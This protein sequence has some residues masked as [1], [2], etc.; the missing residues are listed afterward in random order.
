MN[1]GQVVVGAVFGNDT[2][3]AGMKMMARAKS[4]CCARRRLGA[5]R[6][7]TETPAARR[8]RARRRAPSPRRRSPPGPARRRRNKRRAWSQAAS[9][10]QIDR[11]GRAE[12]RP[13]PA[14]EQ[15]GS[16]SISRLRSCAQID[17]S[18]ATIQVER[19][20]GRRGRAR[21]RRKFDIPG[22][23]AG[24]PAQVYRQT[25]QVTPNAEGVAVLG[26]TVSLKHDDCGADRQRAAFDSAIL[27]D[28]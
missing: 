25:V 9:S 16:R 7:P 19:R 15:W 22:D 5:V 24:L 12:I 27:A 18:A 14:A 26:V 21:C 1:A 3:M 10:G 4:C 20:R 17:A 28:R 13:C 2:S 11:A 8:R 6:L 23:R